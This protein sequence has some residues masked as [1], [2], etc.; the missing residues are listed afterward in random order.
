[1][2]KKKRKRRLFVSGR[3]DIAVQ[4]RRIKRHGTPIAGTQDGI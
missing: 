1:L 2:E 3:K 4:Q